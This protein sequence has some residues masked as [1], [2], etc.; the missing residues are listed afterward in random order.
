LANTFGITPGFAT[1]ILSPL[2]GSGSVRV[3][4]LCAA[5]HNGGPGPDG[6]SNPAPDSERQEVALTAPDSGT[7]A[8][9]GVSPSW[10]VAAPDT[11]QAGSLWSGFDGDPAAYCM[12]TM[13][14]DPPVDVA[15]G[16]LV[17]LGTCD[18]GWYGAVHGLWPQTTVLLPPTIAAAAVMLLPTVVG[19]A[20]INAPLI[21]AAAAMLEPTVEIF[22]PVPLI[23]AAAVMLLPTVSGSAAIAA[24][25]IAAAAAMLLPT[26]S[27]SAAI[28]APKIT[29]SAAVLLP[30]VTMIPAIAFG[31]VG[32]G[33]G[34]VGPAGTTWSANFTV[35]AGSYVFGIIYAASGA[36]SNVEYGGETMTLLAT[37][38]AFSLYGLPDAPGSSQA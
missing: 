12:F 24:P 21:T 6:L 37:S 3:P 33:A 9:T 5:L 29:A 8:L 15:A 23:A 7:V 20:A 14:A 36:A 32:A 38:G 30:T 22:Y 25:L 4:I 35:P 34:A 1:L 19:S 2:A 13:A 26:V 11:I 17:V 28:T 18:L 16:D 10:E 31:A 27:G